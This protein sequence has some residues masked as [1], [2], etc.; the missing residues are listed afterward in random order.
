MKIPKAVT[1]A[2][3]NPTWHTYNQ[4][5]MRLTASNDTFKEPIIAGGCGHVIQMDSPAFV[6]NEIHALLDRLR[7]KSHS[8]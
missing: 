6:A 3:M 2:Y 8:A 5:L 4:G 1:N 7:A